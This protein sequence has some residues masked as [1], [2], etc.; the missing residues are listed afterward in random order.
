MSPTIYID[1][2][3]L[4]NLLINLILLYVTAKFMSL[5]VKTFRFFIA[6][7]FGAIYAV[8]MFLP[9]FSVF[10]TGVA[11]FMSSLMILAIAFNIKSWRLYLKT[12]C[13]F[14]TVTL[15][16]GGTAF[17]F[18][19]FSGVGSRVGAV[20]KNGV[21]Y[22]NLPWQILF[23]SVAVSYIFISGIWR[24]I[25]KRNIKST[26]SVTLQIEHLNK[27]AT[28]TALID[29]GNSLY[30]P[31]SQLP[32]IVAEHKQIEEILPLSLSE[33]VKSGN[34]NFDSGTNLLS[35][36]RVI[37]FSSVGKE[38]GMLFGFRPDKVLVVINEDPFEIENV[39]VGISPTS[40]SKDKKFQALINPA[41]ISCI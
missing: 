18:F 37:P 4:I 9:D 6:S 24:N 36:I 14:Y 39:I 19:C 30:E 8:F 1:V 31:I 13:T 28:L 27:T 11:K 25:L 26:S 35:R 16:F 34:I 23:L 2:L 32:V 33:A 3:F 10:Y 29:T 17:A 22:F 38:N 7:V 40:L 41:V 20:I 15:C 21:L 12:L 5:K